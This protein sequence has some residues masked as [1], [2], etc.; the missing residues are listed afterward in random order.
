VLKNR[1]AHAARSLTVAV[2][3]ATRS[4][5]S[6]EPGAVQEYVLPLAAKP[7]TVIVAQIGPWSQRRI[8]VPIP[9][10]PGERA[11]HVP[12]QVV[13]EEHATDVGLR[14]SAS[15]GIA[16]AWIAIDGQK[17]LYSNFEGARDAAL[18]VALAAGEHD[19]ASKVETSAGVS[20]VDLRRFTRD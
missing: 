12:P 7:K 13:F 6:L 4:L 9:A 19:V 14:A 2:P 5:E 11:L 1:G 8:E 3:G 15:E 16:D 18:D 20:V 10:A 17:Q